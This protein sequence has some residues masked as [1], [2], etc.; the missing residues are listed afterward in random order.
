MDNV[1][2]PYDGV[3]VKIDLYKY[4]YGSRSFMRTIVSAAENNGLYEWPVVNDATDTDTFEIV[5]S[6]SS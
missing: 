1:S 5:I 3:R 2:L 6:S 4:V